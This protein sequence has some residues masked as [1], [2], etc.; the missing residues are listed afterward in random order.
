LLTHVS[1]VMRQGDEVPQVLPDADFS[2]L[3]REMSHKGL[4]AAAVVDAAHQVLGIFT[5]GDLRRLIEKGVD[6]RSLTAEQV[7]RPKPTTVRD[8]VLAAQVAEIME[9]QRITSVLVVDGQGVLR[10]F[11]N[12]NDL[13]RAK[14]I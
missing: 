5:D 10:G 8:N 12:S 6:M 2:T 4:G 3:L 14:V 11:V 7:M 1:D 9:H 13:M